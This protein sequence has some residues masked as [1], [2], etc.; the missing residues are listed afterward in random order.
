MNANEVDDVLKFAREQAAEASELRLKVKHLERR[1][2]RSEARLEN[3]YSS[4]TWRIGRIVLFPLTIARWLE[5][6]IAK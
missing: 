4:W 1:L 5:E 3:I 2:R 6:R